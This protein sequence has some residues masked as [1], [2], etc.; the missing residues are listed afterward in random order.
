MGIIFERE[1]ASTKK[2]QHLKKKFF[3]Q[4]IS[5]EQ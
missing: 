2:P 1:R 4:Y 5:S 3:L